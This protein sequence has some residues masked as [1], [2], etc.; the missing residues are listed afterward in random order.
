MNHIAMSYALQAL[1]ILLGILGAL[2]LVMAIRGDNP[3]IAAMDVLIILANIVLFIFQG[4]IRQRLRA[5]RQ[6]NEYHGH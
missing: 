2:L 5:L 6:L 4:R 1:S 3:L